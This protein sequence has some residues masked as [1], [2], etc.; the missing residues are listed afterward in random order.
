[1]L[2]EIEGNA[3]SLRNSRMNCSLKHRK[4]FVVSFVRFA[5]AVEV[6]LAAAL[7]FDSSEPTDEDLYES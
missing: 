5:D 4:S 2:K 6:L 1:M 7:D 3:F